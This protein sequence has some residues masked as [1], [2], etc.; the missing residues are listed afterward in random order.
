[1]TT[2]KLTRAITLACIPT[3]AFKTSYISVNFI[4]ELTEQS[5]SYNNLLLSV[6]MRGCQKYPDISAVSVR[7]EELYSASLSRSVMSRGEYHCPGFCI[8]YIDGKYAIDDTD[9]EG[10]AIELLSDILLDPLTENGA[11]RAD[12]VESEKLKLCEKIR[13]AKNNKTRYAITRATEI[14][15]E[16]ERYGV[17]G[18]G[19]VSVIEGITPESLYAYYK[20]LIS[21]AAVRISYV[22]AQEGALMAQK[23]KAAFGS[24]D[25]ECTLPPKTEVVYGERELKEITEKEPVAQGKLSIGFRT[26]YTLERRDYHVFALFNELLGGS[27][28]SK[29]FLNVREK[30]S[31]CYYCTSIPEPFKGIMVITSGIEVKNKEKALR[32]VF[33]QIEAI[34]KGDIS[35]EEL[36]GAKKSLVNGYNELTDSA[37]G[38]A[39]WYFSRALAGRCDSPKD[40]AEKILSV[41][42]EEVSLAAKALVPDTVYFLEG[43]LASVEEE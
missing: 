12:Y 4:K 7:C 40:A 2:E 31:L 32:S 10:G 23:L 39:A 36:D 1:M 26:G 43:T 29:L 37:A 3:D 11:F 8:S 28:T 6:L 14:M 24:L 5:A 34:A 18:M 42:R 30:E 27:P 19:S 21:S 13:A 35:E 9:I 16:G 15:C 17:N 41:G 22:G 38:M 33:A 25:H 20:E